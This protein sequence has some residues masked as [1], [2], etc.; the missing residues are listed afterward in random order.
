VTDNRTE[1]VNPLIVRTRHVW[2]LRSRVD[3]SAVW[4]SPPSSSAMTN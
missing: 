3:S 2:V 4:A 1:D